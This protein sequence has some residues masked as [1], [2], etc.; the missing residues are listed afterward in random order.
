M[1]M[2][3]VSMRV[4]VPQKRRCV[5]LTS[6]F[7]WNKHPHFR[8]S[9]VSCGTHNTSSKRK[10]GF[11]WLNRFSTPICWWFQ[12]ALSI[13]YPPDSVVYHIPWYHHQYS[14][15]QVYCLNDIKWPYLFKRTSNGRSKS[16]VKNDISPQNNRMVN[17]D[18]SRNMVPSGKLT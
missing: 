12:L 1:K 7:W 6:G 16:R 15:P 10:C 4:L 5:T 18:H 8:D 9:R 2:I 11:W 13:W 14:I 3:D 17:D